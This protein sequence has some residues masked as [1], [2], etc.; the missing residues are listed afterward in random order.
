[1][2]KGSGGKNDGRGPNKG[3]STGGKGARGKPD[4][5]NR[6]SRASAPRRSNTSKGK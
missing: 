5:S 1:M 6:S 4:Y 3:P 2:A